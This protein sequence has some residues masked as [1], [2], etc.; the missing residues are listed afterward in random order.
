MNREEKLTLNK[1]PKMHRNVLQVDFHCRLI[2]GKYV[3]KVARKRKICTSLNFTFFK[4]KA[5]H[6]ISCL[7]FYLRDKNLRYSGN[8]PYV[9]L[10]PECNTEP[11]CSKQRSTINDLYREVILA[12]GTDFR[13][14]CPEVQ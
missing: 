12:F 11:K 1:K 9:T 8:L 5:Q 3:G 7:Y 14:F 4:K 13:G 10:K 6:F 2:R